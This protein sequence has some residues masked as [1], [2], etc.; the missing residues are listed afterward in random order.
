MEQL[1]GTKELYDVT[2][3]LTSPLE[4]GGKRYEAGE[5]IAAF[6]N[7]SI[8]N[9]GEQK[10]R[11]VAHGGYGDEGLVFWEDTTG[12]A[13]EFEQGVFSKTQ[14]ALMG[15]SYLKKDEK[16]TLCIPIREKVESDENGKIQLKKVPSCQFF[17]YRENGEKI[18]N[19]TIKDNIVT[20]GEPFIT[21][22]AY[23]YY[24][25]EEKVTR[26]EVGRQFIKGFLRLEGKL[27][28]KEDQVGRIS[29]G[30]LVIPKLKIMSDLSMQL[31]K[32]VGPMRVGFS[33][34]GY[35]LGERG[36]K[37][38]CEIILLKDN[39]DSDL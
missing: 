26:I 27:S 24:L 35:P 36:S 30:L 9:F 14:L 22:V 21:L 25:Y 19:Y 31:G 33:G 2:L 17:L 11:A 38:V 32:D 15:N 20:I 7:I 37:R 34:I 12:M 4:A 1:F 8:I 3:K 13:F 6:D 10:K 23:Y 16:Q 29:T 39:I 5:V 28:L 18:T